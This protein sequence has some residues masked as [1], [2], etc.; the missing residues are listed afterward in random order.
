[1]KT[2]RFLGFSTLLLLC[3]ISCKNKDSSLSNEEIEMLNK[4]ELEYDKNNHYIYYKELME[5]DIRAEIDVPFNPNNPNEMLIACR[6]SFFNYGGD[7]RLF[8]GVRD[9]V[10]ATSI[11]TI[12]YAKCLDNQDILFITNIFNDEKYGEWALGNVTITGITAFNVFITPLAMKAY[13]EKKNDAL[14]FVQFFAA[15]K[16]MN[17]L[18]VGDTKECLIVTKC[19][20]DIIRDKNV[21]G[22]NGLNDG[23]GRFW[24]QIQQ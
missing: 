1:M 15:D 4:L 20:N 22:I 19:Q 13:K 5:K 3:S 6:F 23:P 18:F 16:F 2:L 10:F 8:K 24:N 7:I 21:F 11:G 14:I 12:A 9:D 17:V